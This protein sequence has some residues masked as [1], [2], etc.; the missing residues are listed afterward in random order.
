MKIQTLR[1]R[2]AGV[3][4]LVLGA[5]ICAVKAQTQ[6]AAPAAT[7][8]AEQQFKNIQ[9]VK[10]IPADQV[11]PSM[12]FIAN[13]LGVECE[14]CHVE[15]AFDK[16]D[17]KPKQIAR[18][19]IQMQMAINKDH[20][21]GETEVT[22][23]T[24]H[25]GSPRPMAVPAVADA[26]SKPPLTEAVAQQPPAQNADAVLA[27]YIDALGGSSVL[28]KVTTISEKGST[29]LNGRTMAIDIYS[30]AP[31]KR[32]SLMHI[33]NGESVTAYNGQIGWLASPGRPVRD[34]NPTEA[35]SARLDAL[36]QFPADLA[37]QFSRLRVLRPEKID[38]KPVT[39]VLGLKEGQPAVRMFFDDASGLLVRSIRYVETPLGRNPTQVDY[40]D[41]R[42]V[43]GVK[44]PYQWTISRPNG[45]FT[46]QVTEAHLN[47]PIEPAKFVRPPDPPPTP[48]SH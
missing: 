46:I 23:N 34:M 6:A 25:R 20:F 31:D 14:Y 13:A 29:T 35:A 39:V 26:N 9:V 8:T 4:A 28:K 30:Q 41:Y 21:K 45:R 7:K 40:T 44:L 42:T 11:I 1:L 32:I 24:C 22:C 16:D 19:M 12:Q 43:D 33:Q 15:H 48:A 36:F 2:T 18:Q 10:G 38:D 5:S 47:A 3:A 17:K 27:K 37:Q